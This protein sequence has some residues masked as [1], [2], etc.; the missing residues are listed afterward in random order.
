MATSLPSAPDPCAFDGR[1]LFTHGEFRR[2]QSANPCLNLFTHGEFPRAAVT[3]IAVVDD[4][5][6]AKPGVGNAGRRRRF[7]PQ[8]IIP[9]KD[10]EIIAISILLADDDD[11]WW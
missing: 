8:V 3:A 11:D 5:G 10:E 1:G 2:Y 7:K 6:R 4:E 9:H